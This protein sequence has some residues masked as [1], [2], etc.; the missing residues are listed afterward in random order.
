MKNDVKSVLTGKKKKEEE[1]ERVLSNV[2]LSC[3]IS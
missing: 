3:F 1:E 2:K